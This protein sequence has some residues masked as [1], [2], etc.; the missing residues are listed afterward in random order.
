MEN[1]DAVL[2]DHSVDRFDRISLSGATMTTTTH[3]EHTP[4]FRALQHRMACLIAVAVIAVIPSLASAAHLTVPPTTT[5]NGPTGQIAVTLNPATGVEAADIRITY[6]SSIITVSGEVIVG[7]ISANCTPLSNNS[8]PGVLQV[9][10]ACTAPLM[11]SDVL[12][13]IPVNV[14]GSGSGAVDITSC[15]LNEGAIPCTMNGGT[16]VV[17]TP[18]PTATRTHTGTATPTATP[19]HTATATATRTHTHTP[20]RTFTRTATWTATPTRTATPLPTVVLDPLTGPVWV[21]GTTALSGQ[22]F[23]AGSVIVLF[24]DTG[25]GVQPFGPYTPS[26]RTATTMTWNVSSAVPL[27]NGF[28]AVQIVNTDQGYISSNVQPALLQGASAAGLPSISAVNGF[29][30]NPPDLAVPLANVSTTLLQ[31]TT[32]TISGAGFI[33]PVAVLFSSGSSAVALEPL[34]GG[35][36]TQFQVTVPT[37]SPTGPGA[38]QVVNRPSFLGSS[39]VSVPIGEPLRLDSIT[40]SGSVITLR[41]AGFSLRTVI[42]FFNLQPSG[43]VNLGALVGGQ[44]LIPFTLVST[45]EMTFQ[46][47]ANAV[48]GPSYIQLL[49]PP[50]IAFTSTGS[51]PDGVFN[52]TLP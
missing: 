6:P 32:A 10:L 23:T 42:S 14:P 18:T 29:A 39:A 27:G 13:S 3:L 46:V 19:T 52:L 28:A 37:D 36:S 50:F 16:V 33:N 24:M 40:K 11:G 43:V 26:G 20:T 22:N 44:S 34:P 31:G 35:S 51:D 30:I 12:F 47:P 15:T 17:P 8:M 1:R 21:G 38:L 45:H 49:N 41:G 48:A 5:I 2:A 9:G 25:F 4:T 7:G